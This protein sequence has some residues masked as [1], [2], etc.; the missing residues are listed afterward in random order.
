MRAIPLRWA[1]AALLLPCLAL[2]ACGSASDSGGFDVVVAPGKLALPVFDDGTIKTLALRNMSGTAATV[3]VSSALLTPIPGSPFTVPAF[4]ELR[5]PIAVADTWL[6]VE[7]SGATTGLV[8]PYLL[9]ERSG[10]DEEAVGAALL[11][12]TQ[13]A[14]PIHPLTDEVLFLNASESGG[15]ATAADFLF[16]FHATDGSATLLTG[17]PVLVGTQSALVVPVPL[18]SAGHL[19]VVPAPFPQAAPAGTEF[20]FTL[21]THEDADVVLDVDD[22]RRLLDTG[23][24]SNADLVLDFGQDPEGNYHDFELVASNVSDADASFTINSIYDRNGAQILISPRIVTLAARETRVYA[25]DVADS[26]GLVNPEVHPFADL[27]GDV[28]AASGLTAFRM[29]LAISEDL[30]L[31]ARQFDP[32]AG[33]FA[34]RVRPIARRHAVSALVSEAQ[35]TT[36]GGIQNVLRIANSSS[37][38]LTLTVRA[39][40]QT[41]GTEYVLPNVVVPPQSM[42]DWSAD[43]LGLREIVGDL[44]SPEVRN[45]RIQMV[46][47]IPFVSRAFQ[48]TRNGA[49]LIVMMRPHIVR[50]DD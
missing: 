28:F 46:S 4:G 2:G 37:G 14:I 42:L 44:T 47:N 38:N 32:L 1:L 40:T 29:S 19:S 6:L 36:Q 17:A 34:M 49:D 15:F 31:T 26:I 41:E 25:S 33:D 21:A 30:F 16:T 18:G 50:L 22:Q 39:F 35:T 9:Y 8:E 48:T 24:S 11:A 7:T 43:A 27:F 13:S 3:D 45:L 20:A 10:P 5:I 12:S 23:A